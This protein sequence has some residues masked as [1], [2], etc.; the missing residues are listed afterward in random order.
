PDV[1]D[2]G[3]LDFHA[4]VAPGRNAARRVAHPV[5][6]DAEAGDEPD[7][8]VHAE[9]LAMIPA[10]P[11]QRTRETGRVVAAHLD[12]ARAQSLPEAPRGLSEAA[13]PV[14]D[15]ADAHAVPG[16]RDQGGA[17]LLADRV[18]VDDVALEVDAAGRA[19]D[20]AEPGRIVL[21]RVLQHPDAVP[22]HEWRAR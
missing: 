18:V 9:H 12:A 19:G 21:G 22:R 2:G 5:L 17:E 4:G 20:R 8:P 6:A 3:A 15:D 7:R 11:A 13:H 10:E 14:V 1:Q 16:L